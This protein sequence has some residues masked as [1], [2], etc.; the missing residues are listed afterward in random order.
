M[1]LD[2]IGSLLLLLGTFLVARKNAWGWL[3]NVG[4][5]I[6]MIIYFLVFVPR[7]SIVLLNAVFLVLSGKAFLKWR[8]DDCNH[9]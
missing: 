1:Y 6:L 7:L 5:D 3:C 4:G 2:W 8:R 9:S